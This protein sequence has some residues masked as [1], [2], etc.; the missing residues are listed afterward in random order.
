MNVV[1]CG[2]QRV[3]I[4]EMPAERAVEN[5]QAGKRPEMTTEERL[6]KLERELSD[7]KR[8]NRYMSLALAPCLGL[9][10]VLGFLVLSR[11]NDKPETTAPLVD[12]Y[13]MIMFSY[14]DALN[15][16]SR[17]H[18][19]ATFIK[20]RGRA[21]GKGEPELIETH[22]ISWLPKDLKEA[23][24]IVFGEPEPGKN[25]T[26]EETLA[27]ARKYDRKVKK[28]GAFEIPSWL[29]E[30][31]IQHIAVLDSGLVLYMANGTDES[32]RRAYLRQ[33]GGSKNCIQAVSDLIKYHNV[34]LNWGSP[35]SRLILKEDFMPHIIRPGRTH[36][37][38][39]ALLGLDWISNGG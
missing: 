13:Y 22:T 24:R 2:R 4:W 29:F 15:L 23:L 8:H 28:W 31:S 11:G 30:R 27:Y 32:H 17:S 7:V 25:Y 26:L 39:T 3:L 18:T 16:A 1:D 14:E 20:A 37:K 36:S 21:D 34:G 19:F 38:I 6:E 10:V 9:L 33:A 12:R 5:P 35:A